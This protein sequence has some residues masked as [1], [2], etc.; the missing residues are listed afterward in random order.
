MSH[1]HTSR[2][3]RASRAYP[4]V[5]HEVTK[6]PRGRPAAAERADVMAL[7]TKQFMRGER[8]DVQAIAAD[9]GLS[10]A[11]VYRWFGSR[12]RLVGE[13]LAALGEGVIRDARRYARGSGPRRLLNALDRVNRTLAA[14]MPLR[15]FLEAE[16]DAA[17]HILT[18]SAGIVQ[19]RTVAAVRETIEAEQAR[20]NYSSPVDTDT[21]AYAIVRIAEAFLYNDA[22]AGIRG[23]VDRLLEVEAL[24]LHVP[25]Q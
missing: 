19:P 1:I 20:G 7:A 13:V 11:T 5:V 9:L 18:S 16:R 3:K 12:E 17:L 6:R 25:A 22:V 8:I 14:S 23:D 10:R 4:V 21:L 24:L 2:V 15:R